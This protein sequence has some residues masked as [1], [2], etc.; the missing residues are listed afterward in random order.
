M[1]QKS[2]LVLSIFCSSLNFSMWKNTILL[3]NLSPWSEQAMPFSLFRHSSFRHYYGQSLH[4]HFL[5]MSPSC[6][7]CILFFSGPNLLSAS[8]CFCEYYGCPS[9]QLQ[10]RPLQFK[11]LSVI[12]Q[13]WG[14][15]P[16][17]SSNGIFFPCGETKIVCFSFSR[18]S[19]HKVKDS[20]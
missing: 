20:Y 17:G 14:S 5:P 3:Q 13:Q 11:G 7:P 15:K 8:G 16:A 18:F 4:K 1:F 2:Q 9:K 10:D 12:Q 19:C 6:E